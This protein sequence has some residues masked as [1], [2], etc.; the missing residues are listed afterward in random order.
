[1]SHDLVQLASTATRLAPDAAGKVIVCGS[2]G[3]TYAGYLLARE[4]V[5][6]F[7]LNDAGVGKDEAGIGSLTLAQGIGM[8][9]VTVAYD[10]ARI[11]DAEDMLNRGRLSHVNAAAAEAGCAAGMACSEAVRLLVAAS[12]T[13][14]EL[15]QI[16]EA[17]TE[18]RASAAAGLRV[19]CVDSISLVKPEDAGHIVVSGSHGAIVSSQ[20][21][22]AIKVKAALAFYNDAGIGCDDAGITRLPAL[23]EMGVAAATV[24]ADSARIGDAR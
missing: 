22:L 3:A 18:M 2:H 1:M 7:V 6:A 4:N 23:N 13:H 10:S 17:R 16:A 14:G 8:A 9:A 11:G 19:V 20:P 12:D 15:P 21:G 24:T 5:R